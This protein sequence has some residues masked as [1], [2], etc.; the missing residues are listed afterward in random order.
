MIPGVRI[1]GEIDDDSIVFGDDLVHVLF[2]GGQADESLLLHPPDI[3]PG[4]GGQ[5]ELL[6]RAGHGHRDLLTRLL[7]YLHHIVGCSRLVPVLLV[8]LI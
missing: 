5:D 4:Q 2:G 7:N 8:Q 1:L 6:R 3:R